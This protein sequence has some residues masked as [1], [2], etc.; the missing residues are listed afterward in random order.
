MIN[1]VSAA[2]DIMT[3]TERQVAEYF[4][5]H[6]GEFA[7]LTL[8]KLSREANTSTTSVIRFCRRLGFE[9]FKEFQE[10]LRSGMKNQ[11][12]LSFRMHR[13]SDTP[14]GDLRSRVLSEGIEALTATYD[15]LP[16]ETLDA[17]IDRIASARRIMVYG[18]RESHAMVHY[19]Y[20]R[21]ITVRNEVY[22]CTGSAAHMVESML[23]LSEEDL[24]I[25]AIFHRYSLLSMQLLPLVK[26]RGIGTMVF[27]DPPTERLQPY[28]DILLP[29][30][31][32]NEGIKN[33]FVA[34]VSIA[35]Y[36]CN[37]LALRQPQKTEEHI[38]EV[39]FLLQNIRE[40]EIIPGENPVEAFY[41]G[42]RWTEVPP[43][44]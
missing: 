26:K 22:I 40:L 38:R 29:C 39:D 11:S 13:N 44:K 17:A 36:L 15:D 32:R 30:H 1:R 19:I 31:V 10:E 5:T 35:D 9:G 25:F 41:H 8:D 28:A 34:P 18:M 42:S 20:S 12:T 24:C 16:Q 3:K 43:E 21:L 37:G 14:S 23:G 4:L 33:S 27:T 7:F 6:A 2:M